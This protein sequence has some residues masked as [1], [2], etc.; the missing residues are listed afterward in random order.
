MVSI[1][2]KPSSY[3]CS[4]ALRTSQTRIKEQKDKYPESYEHAKSTVTVTLNRDGRNK[5]RMDNLRG[6]YKMFN[7]TTMLQRDGEKNL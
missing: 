1:Y 3:L 2:T 5:R 4:D 6:K 7:K